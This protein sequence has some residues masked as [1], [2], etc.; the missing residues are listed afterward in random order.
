MQ[1]SP[2]NRWQDKYKKKPKALQPKQI[3]VLLRQ[4]L[5]GIEFLK[6][7]GVS[8]GHLHSGNVIMDGSVPRYGKCGPDT[9]HPLCCCSCLATNLTSLSALPR[10]TFV[11]GSLLLGWCSIAG[12]EN[13]IFGYRARL[14]GLLRPILKKQKDAMDSLCVGHMLYE[15]AM[16]YELEIAKPDIDHLFGKCPVEVI[17]VLAHIFYHP[18]ER[19]PSLSE[20]STC[21]DRIRSAAL[22]FRFDAAHSC[23]SSAVARVTLSLLRPPQVKSHPFFARIQLYDLKELNEYHP[24]PVCLRAMPCAA[25]EGGGGW[26]LRCRCRAIALPTQ[27]VVPSDR[28]HFQ[29]EGAAARGEEGRGD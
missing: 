6:A 1:A 10:A 25:R 20:V 7:K 24:P 19:I 23:C 5:E 12:Y 29:H 14:Y 21:S 3:A 11:P 17:E 22:L 13:A 9:V 28:L 8:Y 15:M 16:G 2:I 18:E 27:P 26:Q 4:V